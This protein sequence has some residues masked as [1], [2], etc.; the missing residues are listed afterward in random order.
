MRS[1][2]IALVFPVIPVLFVITFEVVAVD[3]MFMINLA[4]SKRS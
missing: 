3:G 1:K 4:A 2:K